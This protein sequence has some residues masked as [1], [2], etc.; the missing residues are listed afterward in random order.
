MRETY[1]CPDG[2]EVLLRF[3]EDAL[4]V[5]ASSLEGERIGSFQ[6]QLV[7]PDGEAVRLAEDTGGWVSLK[8]AHA[9]L[10]KAWNGQGITERVVTLVS[11]DMS[12]S[13]ANELLK[14]I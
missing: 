7:G 4:I 12:V 13:P 10:S 1:R 2:R 14:D 8:L 6:F 9:D 3:D 5:N 11:D